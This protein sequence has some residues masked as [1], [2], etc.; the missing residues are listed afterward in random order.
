G[1]GNLGARTRVVQ[2][3]T[4]ST[5]RTRTSTSAKETSTPI[6]SQAGMPGQLHGAIEWVGDER[7]DRDTLS[8]GNFRWLR[9]DAQDS[10]IHDFG[11]LRQLFQAAACSQDQ[12]ESC[13]KTGRACV[14]PSH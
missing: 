1:E 14:E 12:H 4:S 3:I 10:E 5:T 2:A 9:R 7:L 6:G 11:R 13:A 8:C